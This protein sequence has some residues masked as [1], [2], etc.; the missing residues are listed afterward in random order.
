VRAVDN[1][2]TT[3][4]RI[5]PASSAAGAKPPLFRHPKRV[6]IVGAG[7]FLVAALAAGAI[8]SADTSNQLTSQDQPKEIESFTPPQGAIVP[9]ST[10]ITVDLRDD[11]TADLTVCGPNPTDCTPIPFDQLRF[12]SGLG[13]LT[14]TP[15]HN[16]GHPSD[17]TDLPSYP[18]GTV[19]VRV[20]YRAQGT[21]ST[22]AGSFTWSFVAK[23]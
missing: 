12:V 22:D 1:G 19:T 5:A 3:P 20:D 8:G 15:D 14:F 9:P 17:P 13:Q 10:S 4:A 6:A 23:A 18:T 16:Y 2:R 11:L 21:Q 7:L